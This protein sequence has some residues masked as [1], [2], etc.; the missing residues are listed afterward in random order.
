VLSS[1]PLPPNPAEL[2]MLPKLASL[3]E[4]LKKEYDYIIMDSAPV[5]L[6]TDAQILSSQADLTLYV[7]RHGLTFK[8]QIK[9]IDMLYRKKSLPRLNIV[10][11]DVIIKKVGYGY[12]GYGYGYGV[13]GES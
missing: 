12:N 13:Y 8:Q 7:V 1:G 3:I 5:G 4:E 10:V 9:L 6:V 2:L 11:N